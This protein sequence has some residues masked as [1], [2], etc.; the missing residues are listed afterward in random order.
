[1]NKTLK[2]FL[3]F[4]LLFFCVSCATIDHYRTPASDNVPTTVQQLVN[5]E[6]RANAVAIRSDE[7]FELTHY[8]IPLR[9][10]EHDFAK[11]LAPEIKQ[12]LVFKKDGQDYVRW[13]I[14]PEDSKW[15]LLVQ[16]FLLEHGLDAQPQNHLKGFLTASRSIIAFDPETNASFSIKV[17]TNL[18]G[19]NWTDKKQTWIDAKQIRVISDWIGEVTGLMANETLIIQEEPFALGIAELDQGLI[20]RSLNDVPKGEKFYLPGFSALHSEEGARIAQLNGAENIAEFW[21]INYN[22]PLANALAEFSA[23][24]GVYY[25]SPHSQNFLIELDSQY[26]PTGKIVLRDFGDAYI[27]DEFV[28]RTDFAHLADIWESSNIL[29]GKFQVSVGLLHG[30][31]APDWLTI[32]EY[33][34]WAKDFY[35]VYEK[36]FSEISSVPTEQLKATKSFKSHNFSYH[37]KTYPALSEDWKRYID[38]ANCLSGRLLTNR[39]KEC[40]EHF[41]R[42]HKGNACHDSIRPFLH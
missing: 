14:N 8:E 10:L 21:N 25:D 13:V 34:D 41:I 36:K 17:S 9:L 28:R 32:Q 26:R 30:N 15:H 31:S 11:S 38:N 19:G 24:T 33:D 1:M 7:I 27:L 12:A 20:V 40:L 4:I 37:T 3:I 23:H 35:A 29:K 39:L 5:W 18:T 22:K 2:Q 42:L 16:E 6:T